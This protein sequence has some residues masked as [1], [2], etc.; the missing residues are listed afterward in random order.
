MNLA[1]LADLP[2]PPKLNKTL[3]MQKMIKP[4]SLIALLISAPTMALAQQANL[5]LQER[6]A[7]QA[8]KTF[9]SDSDPNNGDSRDY[10]S[11]YSVKWNRCFIEIDTMPAAGGSTSII[12]D[13]YERRF[14]ASYYAT[15]KYEMVGCIVTDPKSDIVTYCKSEEE[16][17]NLIKAYME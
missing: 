8:Q 14:F 11:H 13:A 2:N 12:L 1:V 7:V 9:A 6:C 3:G 16:F 15:P 10:T 17:K 4:F 5:D